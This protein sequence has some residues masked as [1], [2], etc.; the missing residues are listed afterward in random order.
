MTVRVVERAQRQRPTFVSIRSI[1]EQAE[2]AE[3]NIDIQSVRNGRRR[4]RGV[5]KDRSEELES[6]ESK[7]SVRRW[8]ERRAERSLPCELGMP[9]PSVPTFGEN[10]VAKT[11]SRAKVVFSTMGKTFESL[12]WQFLRVLFP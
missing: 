2:I 12:L 5:C 4:R 3:E 6:R 7:D 11:F 10:A 8:P 9:G 1:R